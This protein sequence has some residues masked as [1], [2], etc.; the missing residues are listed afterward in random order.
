MK[1]YLDNSA[2]SALHP[3][4]R[5]AMLD[6]YDR[7]G[8]DYSNPSGQYESANNSAIYLEQLRNKVRE[9]A[10]MKYVVFT[11]SASEANSMLVNHAKNIYTTKYV[12]PSVKNNPKVQVADPING[13]LSV[14]GVHHEVGLIADFDKLR[15]LCD[16]RNCKLHVDASQMKPNMK[17]NMK[18]AVSG[19]NLPA[20]FI[21]LSSHKLGGPIGVGALVS[22]EP[23]K[24]IV[25]GGLQENGMRAGTQGLP[26]IAGFVEALQLEHDYSLLKKRLVELVDARYF[27]S[28]Y[29]PGA[30]WADHIVCLVTEFPATELVAFMDIHGLAIAAGS[31][32]TSGAMDGMQTLESF[33][34]LPENLRNGIRV[35][36]AWNTQ[37]ED[38]EQFAKLFAQFMKRG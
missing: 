37:A 32:C 33:D 28:T 10:G 19:F 23:I 11:A 13:V 9:I 3:K 34:E 30:I 7:W 8:I 26:L 16:E 21:T 24:P 22:N 27:L 14:V 20:D 17:F 35:S 2:T 38:I 4:C 36:F 5:E 31:A 29:V 15:A 18:P 25:F 1:I 6:V 12:H